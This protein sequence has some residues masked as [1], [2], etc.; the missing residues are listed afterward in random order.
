MAD[1]IDQ[2]SLSCLCSAIMDFQQNAPNVN[3]HDNHNYVEDFVFRM[4]CDI[5]LS[6]L[7]SEQVGQIDSHRR[8]CN[9]N[10]DLTTH[11]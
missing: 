7:C 11:E 2:I 6:L 10:A 5:P 1:F 4:E 9:I 8:P 3:N